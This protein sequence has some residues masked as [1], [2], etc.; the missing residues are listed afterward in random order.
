MTAEWVGAILTALGMGGAAGAWFA[1]FLQQKRDAMPIVRT[2]WGAGSAGWT[3][4]I[5]MVNRLNEDLRVERAK[6]PGRFTENKPT[7]DDGGSIIASERIFYGKVRS[8][9]LIVAPNSSKAFSLSVDGADT[10]M[11]IIVTVS[12]SNRTLRSKRIK[13][14]PTK[15]A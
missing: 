13:L 3:C 8:M 10:P 15:T 9:D 14:R 6:A 4:K 2:E 5:E 7:Y 12:S 1:T 11:R